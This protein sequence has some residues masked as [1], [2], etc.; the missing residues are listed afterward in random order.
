MSRR[1][2]AILGCALVLL[3]SA[4]PSFAQRQSAGNYD[5]LV[6][7]YN[8]IRADGQPSMADG[9]PDYRPAAVAVRQAKVAEFQ[10]RLAAISPAKW[11]VAQRVDYLLVQA[12]LNALDFQFRVQHPWSSDPGLYVDAV[13]RAA[14]AELPVQGDSLA[15]LQTRL[16]AVPPTLTQAKTNLTEP[17]AQYAK[18]AIHDLERASGVTDTV[19]A[20][21]HGTPARAAQPAGVHGWYVDFIERAKTQ[22]PELVPA[23]Q[24][25]LAAV[26]DFDSW[27][28]QNVSKMTAPAGVGRANFDWYVKYVRYMPYTMEDSVKTGLEEYERAMAFLALERHKNRNLPEI[29][30]PTNKEEYDKRMADAQ[31]AIRAFI[32][33]NDILTIP[34]FAS[35]HLAQNVPWTE[36]P[37]AKRNFWEE[38]QFRDPRPDTVH[39][40]L[41]GHAFDLLVHQHDRR[42]I[43]GSYVDS[44]R[45]EG[46]GFYLEESMLQLGFLDDVPR[47]KEL[48]YIFQAARG[49]RDP[50]EANLHLNKWTIDQAVKY[51][52]DKVPYMDA[53][54]ARIDAAAYLR[55]PSGGLSYQM[56]KMQMFKL[57]GD[58]EHQLGDKFNLR[59]FN[60]AFF[61]SGMIP[62][63][64]IRWEITG[65]DD[66]VKEF[67]KVPDIP[68][69]AKR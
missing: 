60:D 43:R 20:G 62:I 34:G 57:V 4:Y 48:Y 58:R 68:S 33:K 63:S 59:E 31:D 67:W 2:G 37:G 11:S 47:T 53:D 18:L 1:W 61:A 5:A 46:W 13:E 51:M 40:T 28:K 69:P 56:G 35:V 36:R 42:Q 15:A 39:A 12:Q 66:E 38:M 3:I 49:V 10:H 50:A 7:L 17:A 55:K 14:Y 19:A 54:V 45:Q 26:D 24:K 6:A 64:L 22:Q 8:D 23:A 29:A 44:G 27:L 9:V 65:L 16:K 30:L 32:T 41:P 25:A 21:S 52:M